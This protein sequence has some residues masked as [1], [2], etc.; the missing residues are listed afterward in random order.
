MCNSGFQDIPHQ[1]TD[2]EI[3]GTVRRLV[4]AGDWAGIEKYVFESEY[5]SP[6]W[7]LHIAIAEISKQVRPE[8]L[9]RLEHIL[10]LAVEELDDCPALVEQA[11][12][13][14]EMLCE[15]LGNLKAR[16]R[17]TKIRRSLLGRMQ[18]E[19]NPNAP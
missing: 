16:E 10:Q 13:G 11:I 7:V 15:S 19:G 5:L 8:T 12:Y 17:L 1:P 2:A 4:D 3:E 6:S 18:M 9:E 14:V